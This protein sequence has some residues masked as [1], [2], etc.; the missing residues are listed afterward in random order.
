MLCQ[1]CYKK[2]ATVGITQIVNNEQKEL[3]L[4]ESCAQEMGFEQAVS[5]LPQIFTGLMMEILKFKEKENQLPVRHAESGRCPVC[6]SSWSDF[7]RTGLF[8]CD[9]CYLTF[10]NKVKDVLISI[11]GTA[12][13]IG[14]RPQKAGRIDSEENLTFLEH[15]LQDA[16]AKEEFEKA[17]EYRDRIRS[18]K[19]KSQQSV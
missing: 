6:G 3:H 10:K 16:V 13:H 14:Q 4:C 5:N 8:G 19:K 9:N 17:A 11:Q 15:A 12:K 1:R 18:L 2:T 7:K